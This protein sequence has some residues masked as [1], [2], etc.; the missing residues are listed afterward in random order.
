MPIPLQVRQI[1]F[2]M[3]SKYQAVL[4]NPQLSEGFRD[5]CE[6]LEAWRKACGHEGNEK[7]TVFRVGRQASALCEAILTSWGNGSDIAA[8]Q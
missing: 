4:S 8:S 3:I 2:L 1:P 7:S 5:L 6:P